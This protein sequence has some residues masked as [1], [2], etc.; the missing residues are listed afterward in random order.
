MA[1]GVMLDRS[2]TLNQYLERYIEYDIDPKDLEISLNESDSLKGDKSSA[3]QV[4]APFEEK[5]PKLIPIFY[6]VKSLSKNKRVVLSTYA[7]PE[8]FRRN[9]KNLIILKISKKS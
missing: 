4:P 1:H 3:L 5:I 9:L 8:K 6:I 2:W 7:S